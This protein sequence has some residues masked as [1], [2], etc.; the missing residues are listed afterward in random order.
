LKRTEG[1]GLFK[2]VRGSFVKKFTRA[3][4]DWGKGGMLSRGPSEG[5]GENA[6]CWKIKGATVSVGEVLYK[7]IHSGLEGK[8]PRRKK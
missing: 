8:K 6:S 5:K 7:K 2:S 1:R 4:R 3:F